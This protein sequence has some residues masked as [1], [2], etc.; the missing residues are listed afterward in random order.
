MNLYCRFLKPASWTCPINVSGWFFRDERIPARNLVVKATLILAI[1]LQS[2]RLAS[3]HS[4]RKQPQ[5]LAMH[6][7][8]SAVPRM[9][10]QN[11]RTVTRPEICQQQLFS[12]PLL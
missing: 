4:M 6:V 3:A 7:A 1:G 9:I 12:H 10:E 5:F 8:V 11:R 2:T